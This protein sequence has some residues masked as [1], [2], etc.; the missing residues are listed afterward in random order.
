M[1]DLKSLIQSY[2]DA[3]DAAS[4]FSL[5]DSARL[6]LDRLRLENLAYLH[7]IK[8]L[9]ESFKNITERGQKESSIDSSLPVVSSPRTHQRAEGAR[10]PP[11]ERKPSKPSRSPSDFSNLL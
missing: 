4:I 5:V 1:S 11:S 6:D 10:K 7:Q 8:R 3:G 9:G 2:I